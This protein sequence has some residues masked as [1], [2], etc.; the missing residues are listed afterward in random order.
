MKKRIAAL[1]TVLTLLVGILPLSAFAADDYPSEYKQYGRDEVVDRWN[2]YNRECTSFVAWRLN[3]NNGVPFHNYYGGVRWGHAY[4]WDDAA[5]SIGITVNSTPAV[6]AVAYWDSGT[7]GHV[8]WV[9]AV[10]SGNITIEEY[11]VN[12]NGNYNTR[13]ISSSDPSGYIHIRD[14]NVEPKVSFSPW[15][16]DRFTYIRE[17]DAAIGQQIDI[18]NGNCSEDGMVLYNYKGDKLATGRNV[19]HTFHRVYFMANEECGYTLRP[20]TVYKYRF[21]A[22]VNGK[23]Y[24]GDEGSFTTKGTHTHR[25]DNGKRIGPTTIDPDDVLQSTVY[26]CSDCFVIDIKEKEPNVEAELT[27]K[28]LDSS[29]AIISARIS[30][31]D[32]LLKEATKIGAALFTADGAKLG[33]AASQIKDLAP[34]ATLDVQYD[35]NRDM[36]VV[37]KP[38]STYKIRFF[39]VIL[40]RTFWSSEYDI[41]TKDCSHDWDFGVTQADGE[42]SSILYTCRICGQT[43]VEEIGPNEELP[44]SDSPIL[45]PTPENCFID[46][47]NGA[48]FAKAVNWA[49][50]KGVTAG[51]S[52]TTFSPNQPCTRAQAVTFLWRVSGSPE[53]RGGNN[54]FVDVQAGSYYSKAIQWAV[55]NGITGGTTSTTFSPND[56]CTRAQ[57]VCF[58]HRLVGSPAP[59]G[60]SPFVDVPKKAYY[61]TSVAWAVENGITS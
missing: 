46:V 13:T 59:A 9:S 12:W 61:S 4:N 57:I 32:S 52:S 23:T 16:D 30:V 17:T 48:Y 43:R 54:R 31:N 1:L 22:I 33:E 42:R 49:V 40:G 8:A 36:S 47:P 24:W 53:P 11:N 26:H 38:S 35:V 56:K 58:L 51:T 34:S 25:W 44:P 14:L 29:N 37:L 50:E 18:E 28:V 3:N 41:S 21:Y 10:S 2:F 45:D 5:R 60:I 19:P 7:Y 39:V 20:G 55:E 27:G 15:S 6:G